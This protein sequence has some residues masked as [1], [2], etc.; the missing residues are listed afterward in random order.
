MLIANPKYTQRWTFRLVVVALIV[1][2]IFDLIWMILHTGSWWG[3]ANH[4][5]DVELG[6]RRF[7]IIMTY[8]SFIFRVIV[9][10]VF[11]KLSVDFNRLVKSRQTE[12]ETSSLIG[13]DY[14]S[15]KV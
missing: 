7:S 15:N 12:S 10:L 11:W 8:L 3:N 13:K 1:S 4:D 14:S 6:M 9:I 2:W 5:G